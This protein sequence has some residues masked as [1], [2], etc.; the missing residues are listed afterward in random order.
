[1]RQAQQVSL[2]RLEN[3][4]ARR[5][6]RTT[7]CTL[8]RNWLAKK[9][10]CGDKTSK[11]DVVASLEDFRVIVRSGDVRIWLD[12]VYVI[13]DF[14]ACRFRHKLSIP[15]LPALGLLPPSNRHLLAVSHNFNKRFWRIA[16]LSIQSRVHDPPP[17]YES[18]LGPFV[19]TAT[20][21][22]ERD[23]SREQHR[24]EWVVTC[25]LPAL[26]AHARTID[27][28]AAFAVLG[29]GA[30]VEQRFSSLD[31]HLSQEEQAIPSYNHSKPTRGITRI[32]PRS[33]RNL[34]P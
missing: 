10:S 9:L 26:F 29:P 4:G 6:A 11:Q 23:R 33:Y 13:H 28:L 21:I 25:L 31:L 20:F 3:S 12:D 18:P 30:P 19:A 24:P 34:G 16:P 7:K 27:P 1:M 22:D 14:F 5:Q 8:D 17:I 32:V 2:S 15:Q